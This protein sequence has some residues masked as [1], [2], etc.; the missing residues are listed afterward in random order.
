MLKTLVLIEEDYNSKS[1][2]SNLKQITWDI[3]PDTI[4]IKFWKDVKQLPYTSQLYTVLPANQIFYLPHDKYDFLLPKNPNHGD[5]V[6]FWRD[7]MSVSWDNFAPV[8]IWGNGSRIMQCDE[9]LICDIPFLS[10]RLNYI[11]PDYGWVL[12]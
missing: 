7:P 11:N 3:V 5:W 10:I 8:R 4:R 12:T 9:P 1:Y 6:V 2:S